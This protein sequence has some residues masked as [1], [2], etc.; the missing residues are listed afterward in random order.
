MATKDSSI[1]IPRGLKRRGRTWQIC[2]VFNGRL[3]R[4]STGCSDL[5][6]AIRVYRRIEGGELAQPQ[7]DWWQTE[8]ARS[9][10]G[11]VTTFSRML[12]TAKSRGRLKGWEY[13][14]TLNQILALAAESGGR[15]AV[16]GVQFSD[17]RIG[18]RR[19]LLPSLDRIDCQKGYVFTNCRIVCMVV[20]YA[21]SDFGESALRIVARSIV[22]KELDERTRDD[23]L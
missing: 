19:P 7:T 23:Y 3:V 14:L 10:D 1:E 15:C 5:E 21:M 12:A 20:N 16:S 9:R 18:S 4:I 2:R 13:S 6:S 17:R 8:I 11:R 22:K